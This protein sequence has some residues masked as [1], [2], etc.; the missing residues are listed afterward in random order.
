MDQIRYI[1]FVN[2][3]IVKIY[4]YFNVFSLCRPIRI[5]EKNQVHGYYNYARIMSTKNEKVNQNELV[6]SE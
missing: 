4:M 1:I 6:H 3:L 5:A 2:V